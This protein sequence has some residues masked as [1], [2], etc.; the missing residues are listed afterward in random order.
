MVESSE[1]DPDPNE[2]GSERETKDRSFLRKKRLG[3]SLRFLGL[4]L[5]MSFIVFGDEKRSREEKEKEE[6]V[7]VE[8]KESGR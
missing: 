2:G 4:M 5:L 6:R 1:E 7:G 3:L 8:G